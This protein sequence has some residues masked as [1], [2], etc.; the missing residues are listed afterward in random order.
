MDNVKLTVSERFG[1]KMSV[2]TATQDTVVSLAQESQKHLC[3]ISRKHGILDH[4]KQKISG[5]KSGQTGSI[6]CNR[7]R[8]SSINT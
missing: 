7:I 5:E 4:G 3:N 6:I 2:H 1:T 8:M